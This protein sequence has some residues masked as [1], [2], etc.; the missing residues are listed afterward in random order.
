MRFCVKVLMELLFC[1][2][3][4]AIYFALMSALGLNPLYG[5]FGLIL[6]LGVSGI[7]REEII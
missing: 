2:I 4:T 7:I 3:E 6:G 5:L 1:V